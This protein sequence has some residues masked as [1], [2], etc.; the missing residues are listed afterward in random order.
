MN[1]L[2]LIIS[3]LIISSSSFGQEKY[4]TYHG[5]KKQECVGSYINYIEN[6]KI[7]DDH[8]EFS[9]ITDSIL[10]FRREE[11][12][13][14][15]I[16]QYYFKVDIGIEPKM[17][18]SFNDSILEFTDY[19]NYLLTQT[20]RIDGQ[21]YKVYCFGHINYEIDGDYAIYFSREYGI[22]AR[23]T[24]SWFYYSIRSTENFNDQILDKLVDKVAKDKG[25]FPYPKFRKGEMIKE[26]YR[27]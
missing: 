19:F 1:R 4:F 14:G 5:W 12:I 21:P 24:I 22:I 18:S 13:S 17:I 7:S 3:L 8:F 9:M 6:R 2:L 16:G 23:S 11:K 26:W 15:P 27:P 25:F 10:D 20:Y